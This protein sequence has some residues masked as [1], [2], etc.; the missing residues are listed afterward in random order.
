[1]KRRIRTYRFET[2]HHNRDNA[3][4]LTPLNRMLVQAQNELPPRIA[5]RP[6][7]AGDELPLQVVAKIKRQ[8]KSSYPAHWIGLSRRME[9]E[10]TAGSDV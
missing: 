9:V 5:S 6:E 3:M 7:D 4:S 2:L 8:F 10:E 1:M